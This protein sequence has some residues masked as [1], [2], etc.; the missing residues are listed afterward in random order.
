[1]IARDE[2]PVLNI[3]QLNWMAALPVWEMASLALILGSEENQLP[4]VSTIAGLIVAVVGFV[5][6]VVVVLA[7]LV[8]L[9]LSVVLGLP[10]VFGVVLGLPYVFGLLVV[11]G[12]PACW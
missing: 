10:V 7:S 5:F 1:M 4:M 3:A 8:V 11:L 12:L 6:G 9:G 2:I